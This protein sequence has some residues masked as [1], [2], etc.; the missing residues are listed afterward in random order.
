VPRRRT[1]DLI[2]IPRTDAG[3][4]YFLENCADQISVDPGKYGLSQQFGQLYTVASHR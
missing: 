2:Y 4:R 3:L 1:I